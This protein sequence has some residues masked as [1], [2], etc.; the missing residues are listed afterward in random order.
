MKKEL[1]NRIIS[2]IILVPI[3]FFCIIKGSSYFNL[4]IIFSFLLTCFEWNK[5]IDNIKL[6]LSG[7]IFLII[8]YLTV[9]SVRNDFGDD[10]LYLFLF[11]ILI[12]I[13]TDLGG[14]I[15]GK[16]IKGPK[17]T[18][19]SP[20]KTISGLFGSFVFSLT[21]AIL[22]TKNTTIIKQDVIIIDIYF[23]ITIIIISFV[24]QIGDLIISFF[25]RLYKIKDTGN[26]IPGHGGILDRTDGMIFAYPFFY[27]L[28]TLNLFK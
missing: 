2:S 23:I 19:I 13:S 11:V 4:L 3:V 28:L 24:S 6:K 25:K 10:S 7:I 16:I 20:N 9:F 14:Y 12:C 15:V 17:L 26:F 1:V 21:V 22:F 27:I 18:K 8:S 5:M